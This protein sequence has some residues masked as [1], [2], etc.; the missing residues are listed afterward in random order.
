VTVRRAKLL[1]LAFLALAAALPLSAQNAPVAQPTAEEARLEERTS[2]VA[3]ELRCPVCQGLSIEDSPS[4]MARDMRGIVKEQLAEGKSPEEIKEYFVRGYGEWI[5]LR[6]RAEGFNL[7]VYILP[8]VLLLAGAA[9][10]VVLTRRWTRASASAAPM[11]SD[12][13][14]LAE[15]E[16]VSR[17]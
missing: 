6:P 5:L 16:D 17:G 11:T 10:I 15:W 2:R 1:T 9:L 7:A 4:D 3:S 14:E 8:I 12:D 13:P